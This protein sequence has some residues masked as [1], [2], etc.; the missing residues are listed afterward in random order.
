MK[1]LYPM[2]GKNPFLEYVF[3]RDLVLDLHWSVRLACKI[4]KA[5][6]LG[7]LDEHGEAAH[8]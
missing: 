1:K 3:H 8:D 4:Q 2:F 6:L 5:I 7:K